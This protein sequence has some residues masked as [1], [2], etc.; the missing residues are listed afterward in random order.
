MEVHAM[1]TADVIIIG[2]GTAGAA[3]ALELARRKVHVLGLDARRPPHS[4]GSHHGET[5][6]VRRAY[7]E[8]TAYVPMAQRAW[9][10]W[11]RLEHDCGQTLLVPTGNLTIGPPEGS[12]VQGFLAS[13]RAHLIPHES[14]TADA[15][16]RRWPVLAVPDGFVAG[17]EIE[18]G[19]VFPERA[20]QVMLARA[21]AAGARLKFDEPA[22][23]WSAQEAE[24]VVDTPGGPYAAGRLLVS[25]GAW[26]PPFI[27][28]C[29]H[30]LSPKR[31]PVCWFEAPDPQA[32]GLGQMPVNFWQVP[33]DPAAPDGPTEMEFYSLPAVMAGGR[34]KAAIHKP[35]V[36]GDPAA[37]VPPVSAAEVAALQTALQRF[38][39][40]LTGPPAGTQICFY[41]ETLDGHFLLGPLPEHPFMQHPWEGRHHDHRGI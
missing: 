37:A 39:P 1:Q 13:A 17:L 14:L 33:G 21:E 32:Y 5:R 30:W 2:L 15:V 31:V 4:H 35:L 28:T 3:T 7:L 29:G 40:G 9:E 8:G 25:A 24:V 38:L 18:A 26:A 16:R 27:G 19:I 22:I 34:I 10:N 11:R 36:A 6:S 12:A 23:A 20:L 41:T